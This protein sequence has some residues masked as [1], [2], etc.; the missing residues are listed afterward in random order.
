MESVSNWLQIDSPTQITV[1]G[2]PLMDVS[3]SLSLYRQKIIF[4][5]DCPYLRDIIATTCNIKTLQFVA[6]D[7]LI[8]KQTNVSPKA[9]VQFKVRKFHL[10]NSFFHSIFYL[11]FSVYVFLFYLFYFILKELKFYFILEEEN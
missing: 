4:C 2:R 5:P 1:R 8:Y 6:R 11:S 7:N 10:P 3:L 9:R